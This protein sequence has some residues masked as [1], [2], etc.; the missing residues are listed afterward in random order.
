MPKRPLECLSAND[1]AMRLS[2]RHKLV[3]ISN[4]RCGSS[5]IGW[6][7]APYTEFHFGTRYRCKEIFGKDYDEMVH[8]P[9]SLVRREF[10]QQSW[11]FGEYI[12]ISSVRNPW[13]RAVSLY[14]HERK[15]LPWWYRFR[16]F[17]RF[18]ETELPQ[19]RNGLKNR[20]TSYDMFHDPGGERLVNYVVRLEQLQSDLS[21]IIERHWPGLEL[22]FSIWSNRTRHASYARYYTPHL[23]AAVADMFAYDIEEWGYRFEDG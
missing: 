16:S 18:V 19:W 2:H 3:L 7:F 11:N 10:E 5:T 4:W 9:A 1:N 17:K 14:F 12:S 21:P 22:D 20:W 8:Y 13:A 6:M 15:R 23:Q